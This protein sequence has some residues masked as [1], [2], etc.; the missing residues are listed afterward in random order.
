MN[1][2]WI[3]RDALIIVKA[4]PNPSSKYF[5]TVCV[6]AITAEEGWVRL[7]PINFR[8]LPE[9]QRFTKYQIVRLRMKKHETDRRP[10]S[11][12]VDENSIELKGEV[13]SAHN[14]RERWQWTRPTIGPSM[15]DMVTQ[16]KESGKSLACIRPRVVEGIEVED[17][18][19]E[20]SD[21]KKS[22]LDQLTL[23]DPADKTKLEKIPFIFRYKYLCENPACKGH[24]QSIIDWELSEFYRRVRDQGLDREGIIAAVR[25]RFLGDL[26]GPTK[27][28]HFFVGNHSQYPASF[29]I[30]GVFWPPRTA[31]T[32]LF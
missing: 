18:E 25:T 19:T 6:A 9:E 21:K 8:S 28:T 14:W 17:G 13:S 22:V 32:D 31:Q 15:C 11:Y 26:C 5:E 4:Y 2:D 20:W 7:Y 27:D 23:F 3:T 12:R 10:E 1:D 24:C 16:Q 29:M 30:L